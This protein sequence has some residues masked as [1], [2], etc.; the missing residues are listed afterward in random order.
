MALIIPP[1]PI[2]A[3]F[4]SYNWAD[5]YEKVRRAINDAAN[6]TIAVDHGG[7][8]FVS[9]AVGDILAA[10]TSTSF[11]KIADVA[12][13]N[14]L[15]SGG[16]GVLPLWG[17]IG[18]TTHVSGNLPVANLN[19]GT[20]ASSST[21]WRGDAT[22]VNPYGPVFRAKTTAATALVTTV[23][24]K[25]TLNTD[26]FDSDNCFDTA[27]SKFTPNKAGYYR[28][29]GLAFC[30]STGVM[31]AGAIAIY[32]NGSIHSLGNFNA[33]PGA[34]SVAMGVTDVFSMNGSTDF[35]ELYARADGT[36]TLEVIANQTHLVY[37]SGEFIRPL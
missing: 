37:L 4:G 16:V 21:F 14:A 22:W 10:N 35:V 33:A 27:T 31:A 34:A 26:D 13:G 28:F 1:S 8:G 2:D 3:P 20:G 24:A 25:V 5:W 19:S 17:K 15:I 32:K 12:T 7:T 18:L 36:G 9:Y 29:S 30:T 11:A 6:G 23:F